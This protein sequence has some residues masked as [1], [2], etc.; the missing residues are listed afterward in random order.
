[1]FTTYRHTE[2]VI[3]GLEGHGHSQLWRCV[4][5]ELIHPWF[6][7][8]VSRKSGSQ[9]STS[10]MMVHHAQELRDLIDCQS[11]HTWLDE[12][13]LVTPPHTNG[14]AQWMMEKLEKLS[15]L[16]SRGTN[17]FELQYEVK[18]GHSYFLN[19]RHDPQGFST[20]HVLFDST[21]DLLSRK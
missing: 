7:L 5:Q 17:D 15:V 9:I 2:M 4:E 6:Y 14:Q 18:G 8:Q 10:M 11:S 19:G 1:M 3:E 21:N 12:V 20:S 16:S 13:M